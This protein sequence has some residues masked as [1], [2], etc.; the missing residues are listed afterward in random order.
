MLWRD[1][2]SFLLLDK[3]IARQESSETTPLC[4][5]ADRHMAAVLMTAVKILSLINFMVETLYKSFLRHI[6][7]LF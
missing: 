6:H 5:V 3:A 1:I 4:A 7:R 2:I